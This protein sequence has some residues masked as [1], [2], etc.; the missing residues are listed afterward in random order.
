MRR[1]A[2]PYRPLAPAPMT[3]SRSI[4]HY[5][6]RRVRRQL[7]SRLIPPILRTARRFAGAEPTL[8]AMRRYQHGGHETFGGYHD[9]RPISA[10]GRALLAHATALV[11]RSPR[12]SDEVEIGYFDRETA[13]FVALGRT[14]LWCW[15][16]GAR[17]RW[18]P[19]E[20]R[21]LASNML[22]G[23]EP[24]YCAIGPKRAIERLC[25]RPLFDVSADGCVGLALNFG[26]LA[27][28]RPG[29]GYPALEDPFEDEWLP[30]GDGVTIV[31]LASGQTTGFVSLSSFAAL[32]S[33]GTRRFHYLNSGFLSPS[34][35]RFSVLH[36]HLEHPDRTAHWKVQAVIG[37]RDGT[38]L[39]IVPLP[40]AASHSSWIDDERIAYTVSAL[41]FERHATY[42]LY[43][44]RT[45]GVAPLHAA[46]PRGDGHPSLDPVS[47][48][49]ITDSYPD[50]YDEQ[51]LH[52]LDPRGSCTTLA[53]LRVFPGYSGEWRCDLH[54]RWGPD[55]S[56][57][58]I[59]STHEGSRAMYELTTSSAA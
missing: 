33:N 56:V 1:I 40:G 50:L 41:P 20:Q 13:E 55:G 28:T 15:Q 30:P 47:G 42:F 46:A 54:P 29:Y 52:V 16:L 49:W 4:L 53:R 23:A 35:K 36:K 8:P 51:A 43:D 39:Q 25:S 18:W 19:G 3:A 7:R 37:N 34:G 48:R 22:V 32:G 10:D 12:A 38:D 14:A 27:R 31:E 26:R 2:R 17:L 5:V 59:D 45:R 11:R 58:V 24:S 44:T 57:V 9:I 21:V 6:P